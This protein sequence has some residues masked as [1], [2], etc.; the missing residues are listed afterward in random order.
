MDCQRLT[1]KKIKHKIFRASVVAVLCTSITTGC[2]SVEAYGSVISGQTGVA[3]ISAAMSAYYKSKEP[4]E[5][6]DTTSLFA[7]NFII[8]DGIAI[9][10]VISGNLNIRSGPGTNYRLVGVL[11]KN[12]VCI[13][14]SVEG[15][16]AKITSG[17]VSGYCHTDYLIMGEEATAAAKSLFNMV[18]T[19]NSDISILNVRK[20][21]ST[22]SAIVSTVEPGNELL[23]SKEA[24]INKEDKNQKVWVEIYLDDENYENNVAY[25]SSEYVT[26]TY[27]LTYASKYTSYGIGVSDDR[28]KMLD[29]AQKFIGTPYLWGGNDLYKGIDCSGFV[30]KMYAYIGY[31]TNR[32]SRDIA[33]QG[34]EISFSEIKPGD[35]IFYGDVSTGYIT[36]VAIYLGNNKIIHSSTN[37][38]GVGISKYNFRKYLKIVQIIED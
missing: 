16:W 13:V 29:Y 32:V 25:V 3:G 12:A 33:K 21:P 38:K 31:T 22:D 6:V 11:P 26:I 1:N 9:T 20:E 28:V 2:L 14:E 23:V 4:S 19:V 8:P 30:K 7:K 36:H 34:K 15:E 35:L 37:T 27:E 5:Q 10:D 17:E 24:V 18:A